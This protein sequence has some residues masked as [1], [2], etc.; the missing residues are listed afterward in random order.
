MIMMMIVVVMV[1]VRNPGVIFSKYQTID[2]TKG[3][4]CFP[5]YWRWVGGEDDEDDDEGSGEKS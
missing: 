4:K 2:H 1:M 5:S 3:M